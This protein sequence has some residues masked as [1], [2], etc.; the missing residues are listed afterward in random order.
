MAKYGMSMCV[1]GMHEE[2]RP[3]GIAV[4]ALWPLT[5]VLDSQCSFIFAA[6]WTSAMEMLSDGSGASGSRKADIMVD[7][8]YAILS[9]NSREYTGNFAIDEDL[10]RAEGVTDFKKY[11]I[12]PDSPLTADFFIPNIENYP[13][14]FPLGSPKVLPI[15]ILNCFAF[16]FRVF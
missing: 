11:A 16:K 6:I 5:G 7:A 14:T 2:F 13:E 3:Y 15:P 12:D 4:N 1:L 10:L 8:A 9:K